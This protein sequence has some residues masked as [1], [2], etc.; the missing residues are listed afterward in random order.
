MLASLCLVNTEFC[1][2][3][4]KRTQSLFLLEALKTFFLLDTEPSLLN[5][6]KLTKAKLLDLVHGLNMIAD[7]AETLVGR[8]IKR[9][10]VNLIRFLFANF[11]YKRVVL[12]RHRKSS[13]TQLK[14]VTHY[15]DWIWFKN[16]LVKVNGMRSNKAVSSLPGMEHVTTKIPRT[17]CRAG[18][19]WYTNALSYFSKNDF[20]IS[21]GLYLEQTAVPIGSLLVIF[22]SRPDCLPQ[23]SNYI[24]IYIFTA[25]SFPLANSK[26]S[27]RSFYNFF[28][29]LFIHSYI[30][31]MTTHE[32]S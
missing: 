8:C 21:D 17:H 30:N 10:K 28:C 12:E 27:T 7:S 11:I 4:W 25:K 5:R 2:K 22:E 20:Q 32:I 1:R 3:Y 31:Y 13:F 18:Q 24:C 16:C 23:V 14:A 9:V 6:L 15:Q 26:F 19:K 29:F